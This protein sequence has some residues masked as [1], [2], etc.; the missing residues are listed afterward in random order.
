M[1][2]GYN[3]N[4]NNASQQS[5][6]PQ[7]NLWNQGGAG[8]GGGPA[9]ASYHQQQMYPQSST[10]QSINPAA[11][12]GGKRFRGTVKSFSTTN[13]Y[14]FVSSQ[15]CSEVFGRDVFINQIEVDKITG[16]PQ[17]SIATGTHLSFTVVPNKKSQPQA[18]EV[19][20]ETA[21]IPSP[22]AVHDGSQ[23]YGSTGVYNTSLHQGHTGV[24]PNG[25]LYG[26]AAYPHQAPTTPST[27]YELSQAQQYAQSAGAPTQYTPYGAEP[28]ADKPRYSPQEDPVSAMFQYQKD[29]EQQQQQHQL[30]SRSRSPRRS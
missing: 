9:G 16:I 2:G 6:Q 15:E 19:Q 24:A 27:T 10:Q 14:G 30:R 25:Q 26:D 7:Q 12:H 8:D 23:M 5:G 11:V 21:G 29:Y 3:N 4:N 28:I 17:S 13:G 22:P 18:R 1:Y 20:V